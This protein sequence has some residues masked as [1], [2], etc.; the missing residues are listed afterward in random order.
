MSRTQLACMIFLA[1]SGLCFAQ[2]TVAAPDALAPA[3]SIPAVTTP[4]DTATPPAVKKVHA[5]KHKRAAKSSHT[6]AKAKS[7][8][9]HAK[10]HAKKHKASA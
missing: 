2:G 6:S 3:P 1:T 7:H 10:S 9:H 5:K 4:T 8:K